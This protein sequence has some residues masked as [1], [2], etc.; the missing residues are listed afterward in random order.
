MAASRV[1]KS[2]RNI[3]LGAGILFVAAGEWGQSATSL[4][5]PPKPAEVI[6]TAWSGIGTWP[7]AW[8]S[9]WAMWCPLGRGVVQVGG[10]WLWGFLDPVP[11]MS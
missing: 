6:A 5:H 9:P 3:I 1:Y 8:A 4:T 7:K 11:S 2:K 10:A